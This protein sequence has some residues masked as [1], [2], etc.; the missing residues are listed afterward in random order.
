MKNQRRINEEKSDNEAVNINRKIFT[1]VEYY[2][3]L[4][5]SKC[6]KSMK[7][8]RRKKKQRRNRYK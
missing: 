1:N 4:D 8:Q 2:V 5:R 6:N 7:N 3:Y